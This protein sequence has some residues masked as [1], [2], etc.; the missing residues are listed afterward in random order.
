[1]PQP[2]RFVTARLTLRR[3]EKAEWNSANTILLEGEPGWESDTLKLK[4]GDGVTAWNDLNY[5]NEGISGPFLHDGSVLPSYVDTHEMAFEWMASK[6]RIYEELGYDDFLK[7]VAGDPSRW[8]LTVTSGSG[9]AASHD[10]GDLIDDNTLVNLTAVPFGGY[11]FDKWS[12]DGTYISDL[13][14][15][16]STIT[17]T[18]NRFA[19]AH[20]KVG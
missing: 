4:I 7:G 19:K 13:N 1:M 15:G 9:G 16:N 14:S 20:F 5:F 3:G 8:M 10:G 11:I 6:F 17:I 2:N 18:G 12:G